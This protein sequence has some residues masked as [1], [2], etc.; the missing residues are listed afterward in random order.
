MSLTLEKTLEGGVAMRRED[1]KHPLL[2]EQMAFL[3]LRL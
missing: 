2:G 3:L 1:N